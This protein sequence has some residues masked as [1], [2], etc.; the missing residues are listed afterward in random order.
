MAGT[1]GASAAAWVRPALA[2]AARC[3]TSGALRP[4]ARTAARS[5][6]IGATRVAAAVSAAACR[7]AGHEV[8]ARGRRRDDDH[9]V[10]A[11]TPSGK[12][13]SPMVTDGQSPGTAQLAGQARAV[14]TAQM[15]ADLGAA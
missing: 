1:A 5:G 14:G 6:R 3:D 8:G 12:R 7:R 15:T 11:P 4:M 10:V 2:A 13:R 9:P